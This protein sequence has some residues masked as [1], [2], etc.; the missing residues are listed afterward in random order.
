MRTIL[1][2]LML[3]V[4]LIG[5]NKSE[6]NLPSTTTVYNPSWS[7]SAKVNGVLIY[8]DSARGYIYIDTTHSF[9]VRAFIIDAYGDGKS[10]V[11][12]FGDGINSTTLTT[13]NYTT[14]AF[15]I[16]AQFQYYP[17]NDSINTFDFLE[18]SF[19][20]SVVDTVQK[21]ISGDFSGILIGDVSG[22]TIKITE[23]NFRNIIYQNL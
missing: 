19:R 2:L 20:I 18:A 1:T 6:D 8:A 22:D 12:G 21:K 10:I 3:V 23:G 14:S 13:L 7:F 5:C 4:F 9:P 15:G 17:L 16:G 11:P